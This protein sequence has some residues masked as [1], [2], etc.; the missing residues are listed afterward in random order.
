MLGDQLQ[1]HEDRRLRSKPHG[2]QILIGQVQ[3]YS[4]LQISG[5][6]VKRNAL[7]NNRDLKALGHVTRLFSR[8][9]HSFNCSL[10]H[11]CPPRILVIGQDQEP[12]YR[13]ENGLGSASK[14]LVRANTV[15]E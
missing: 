8:S 9:N 3:F 7:R 5:D 10:Q 2:S 14:I 12:I 1:R 15:I 4:L 6:L 13:T 11:S